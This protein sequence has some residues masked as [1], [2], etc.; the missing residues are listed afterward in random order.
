M[1]L[2]SLREATRAS[3]DGLE[4][5]LDISEYLS[6]RESWLWLLETFFGFWVPVESKIFSPPEFSN[7]LPDADLRLKSVLLSGDIKALGGDP[8]Q[9][10]ICQELPVF[11]SLEEKFGGLYVMEGAT[12]GGQ[13]ISRL[14]AGHGY[15][16]E[17]GCSFFT[18]YGSNV[19]PMWKTFSA[20]LNEFGAAHTSSQD[21]VTAAAVD[22]FAKFD[23]WVS[24][25]KRELSENDSDATK[26]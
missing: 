22:T 4:A 10:E 2:G 26:R 16:A 24:R 6:T 12:L 5:S 23:S 7:W 8:L 3:H 1:L 11:F 20:Q 21:A 19:G 18:S 14:A 15:T 9:S 17:R 13:I 25:R